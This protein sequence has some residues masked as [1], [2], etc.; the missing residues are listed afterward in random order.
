M[1]EASTP[2]RGS[3]FW[4]AQADA[5]ANHF[6]AVPSRCW[7]C[8]SQSWPVSVRSSWDH[9]RPERRHSSALLPSRSPGACSSRRYR[10]LDPMPRLLGGGLSM[11]S[12]PPDI[13]AA[14]DRLLVRGPADYPGRAG[15]QVL[16]AQPACSRHRERVAQIAHRPRRI[17]TGSRPQPHLLIGRSQIRVLL[18]ADRNPYRQGIGSQPLLVALCSSHSWS[19]PIA[20]SRG[21]SIPDS[22]STIPIG[23]SNGVSDK[24]A[25]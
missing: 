6:R 23:S 14:R 11:L 10:G 24:S 3:V 25:L 1:R 8:N 16:L 12:I 22:S 2:Q 19:G 9:L 18:W 7:H 13:P 4:K 20:L 17:R 5:L 21:T 15:A